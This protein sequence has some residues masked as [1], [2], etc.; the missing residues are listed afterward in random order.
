MSFSFAHFSDPHLTHLNNAKLGDLL[1]K[2]A[3]GYLSW[4]RKRRFEHRPE[5]LQSLVDHSRQQALD[6]YVVTGDLTH[7]GLPDEYRQALHWL[8]E[9]WP[10]ERVSLIPG[11]HECCVRQPWS[12]GMGQWADYLQQASG[13]SSFPV[14]TERDNVLFIGLSSACPTPPLMATG[15]VGTH[16]LEDLEY[17]L[18][19]AAERGLFRVV[20]VHHSPLPGA[21][22]WRKRMTDQEALAEVL[23]RSGAELV[24][25]GHGHRARQG[26]LP[27][28]HGDIPVFAVPSASARA[29]HGADPAGYNRLQVTPTAAGWSLQVQ[30]F[31]LP[32]S[33]ER[34][35]L[36]DSLDL[37]LPR[38][39]ART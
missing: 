5:V 20:C 10:P 27:S 36:Q 16:Q 13:P 28:V 31:T 17:R 6:H 26:T 15:T 4:R 25:H 12:L 24:L 33:V 29:L 39:H 22:K 34:V 35:S 9:L 37:D 8:R 30:R 2:R 38:A 14:L 11:N 32:R 21:E 19:D 18:N 3:L 1:S 7:I 23:R